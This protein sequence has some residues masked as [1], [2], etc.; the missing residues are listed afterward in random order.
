MKVVSKS[1]RLEIHVEGEDVKAC[2]EN[3]AHAQEVFLNT[4]CGA[5]DSDD[6]R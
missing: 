3:M 1:D 5:C 2:F 6:V 4:H